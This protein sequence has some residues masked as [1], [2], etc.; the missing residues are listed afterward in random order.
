MVTVDLQVSHEFPH[1][2]KATVGVLN[3][4]DTA[5]PFSDG[6]SEGY[7]WVTHDPRGRFVYLEVTKKF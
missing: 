1:G 6:E 5:P 4:A 2:F 7:D 3:I